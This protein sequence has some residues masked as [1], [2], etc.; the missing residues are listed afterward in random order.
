[1]VDPEVSMKKVVVLWTGGKDSCLALHMAREAYEIAAL[2]TFVP[3]A[4][5]EFK[6]HP[7]N[8]LRAQAQRLGLPIQFIEIAEPYRASYV[9]ALRQIKV[10]YGAAAVI[11]GDID[12]VEGQPNWIEQCCVGLDLEVIRPLWKS[13]RELIMTELISR[14]IKARISLINHPDIPLIWLGRIIDSQMLQDL[15]DL[16][17]SKGIDLAGENGE[18]HTMVEDAPMFEFRS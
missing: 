10:Q 18:F 12:E 5:T 16:S 6:A 15:K 7:Q 11:T 3:S 13:P 2:V 9:S 4:E 1:M 17:Q 8:E 14:G